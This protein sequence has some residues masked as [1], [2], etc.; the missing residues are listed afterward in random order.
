MRSGPRAILG[1]RCRLNHL[2]FFRGR[3]RHQSIEVGHCEVT[4]VVHDQMRAITR[5]L[6]SACAIAASAPAV[7]GV[8]RWL[9]AYRGRAS[10]RSCCRAEPLIPAHHHAFGNTFF[11]SPPE[12]GKACPT[13]LRFRACF[14]VGIIK[15]RC[16]SP[17]MTLIDSTT[18]G[19]SGGGRYRLR[20]S[21]RY[22]PAPPV[23]G[24]PMHRDPATL[25]GS[26]MHRSAMR[27]TVRPLAF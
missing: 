23:R 5:C 14:A 7:A 25:R 2:D 4:G 17:A 1:S 18:C 21:R 16:G 3:S 9:R 26:Q 6:E 15:M 11:R 27:P 8:P 10:A 20:V 24:S 12:T 13:A 19:A 22:H